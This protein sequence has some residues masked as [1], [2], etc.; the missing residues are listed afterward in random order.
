MRTSFVVTVALVFALPIAAL[1]GGKS[2]GGGG[3]SNSSGGGTGAGKVDAASSKT[4]AGSATGG[5]GAGKA[6]KASPFFQYAV[7]GK[8]YKKATLN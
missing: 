1:A 6:S 2:G 5:S 7:G 8:H 3:G 4:T